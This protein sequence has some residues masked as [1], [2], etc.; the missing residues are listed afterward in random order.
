[1]AVQRYWALNFMEIVLP[2]P[3][4]KIDLCVDMILASARALKA[5]KQIDFV[6]SILLAGAVNEIL[7]PLLQE[8]RIETKRGEF[9]LCAARIAN[10]NSSDNPIHEKTRK[11]VFSNSKSI[12]N[13]LKHA[14]NKNRGIKPSDDLEMVVDLCDEAEWSLSFALDNFLALRKPYV[15]QQKINQVYPD[16]FLDLFQTLKYEIA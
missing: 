3:I 5:G 14:G 7:E 16:E 9:A 11:S 13:A 4:N 10:K 8:L 1:M 2:K 6:T 12:Y 15:T